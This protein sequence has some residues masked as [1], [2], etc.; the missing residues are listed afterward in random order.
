[1]SP[2]ERRPEAP[3]YGW[4]QLSAAEREHALHVYLRACEAPLA[5]F[6]ELSQLDFCLDFG[7]HPG[8]WR[9][10]PFELDPTMTF[11]KERAWED[12][13]GMGWRSR[14]L[15]NPTL[16]E[17]QGALHMF[18][19]GN[20]SKESQSGRVGHAVYR[21]GEGWTDLS[22]PPVLWP[23]ASDELNSLEDPKLYRHGETYYLFYN[24][25]W[26]PSAEFSSSVRAGYRDWGVFVVTKLATSRDLLEFERHGQVVP[27]EV[28]RGWSKGAVIPRSP[29]GDAV[30]IGGNFLMFLSEGCGD[31]QMLGAST[32][33]VH[34]QFKPVTFL[35]LPEEMGQLAEV[36]CCVAEF[37][38]SGAFF[39]LDF[40]YRD[41]QRAWRAGQ[42]LYHVDE[43]TRPLAI[44]PG[45]SLAWGGLLK[46]RGS[47]LVMQGWDSPSDRQ[48]LYAYR[49]SCEP[50]V[51]RDEL[52][53][54]G[55]DKA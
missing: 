10:G 4:D 29:T 55:G 15:A 13:T 37:E 40:F 17:H 11:R 44:E 12:P 35:P 27:Y 1:M 38:P 45:G 26:E 51:N 30:A 8:D 23:E 22:G 14:V 47:W 46:H 24:S 16:I 21:E 53:V 20:P 39:I 41:L 36:A 5:Q 52:G 7:R 34:W 28:S 2:E 25:V 31:Q 18:Y 43:P 54:S 48:E 49:S 50:R 32:D 19:R 9:V 42:A 3:R 33:L 6:S